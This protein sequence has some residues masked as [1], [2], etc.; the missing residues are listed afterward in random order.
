MNKIFKKKKIKITPEM[1]IPIYGLESKIKGIFQ[2]A[3]EK[4]KKKRKRNDEKGQ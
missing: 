3:K 1:K 2:R 4:K